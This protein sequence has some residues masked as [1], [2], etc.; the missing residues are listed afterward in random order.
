MPC[1]PTP[2]PPPLL[3][4]PPFQSGNYPLAK[5]SYRRAAARD[6]AACPP[7]A[8]AR[9]A[10]CFLRSGDAAYAA[11]A[12]ELAAAARPSAAAWA[13]AAGARTRL[14]EF[15]AAD[16]ALARASRRDPRH[17][18]VWGRLALLALMQG[19]EEEAGQVRARAPACC[20]T[21]C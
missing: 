19:R 6:P 17:P 1:H 4:P 14:R 16:A 12:F 9:L 8:L 15:G 7:R 10:D 13:A 18:G 20:D 3:R 5:Q 11:D 21:V 2:L